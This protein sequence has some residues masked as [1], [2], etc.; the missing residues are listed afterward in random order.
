[1][2]PGSYGLIAPALTC[3]N[4]LLYKRYREVMVIIIHTILNVASLSQFLIVREP[5]RSTNL[6]PEFP[7]GVDHQF[8]R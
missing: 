8:S 3:A 6:G 1:M 2:L 7:Q 4:M 5:N